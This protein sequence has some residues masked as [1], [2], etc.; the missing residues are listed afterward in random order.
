MYEVQYKNGTG[1]VGVVH[2][3]LLFQCKD[4]PIDMDA[5]PQQTFPVRRN[6]NSSRNPYIT[7]SAMQFPNSETD[8]SMSDSSD[9]D[10]RI[11]L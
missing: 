11:R 4:L 2:R 5:A 1:P 6:S 8:V 10:V 3:N 7:R 9:S